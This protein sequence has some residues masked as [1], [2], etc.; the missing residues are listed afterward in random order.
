[1]QE[2]EWRHCGRPD[3]PADIGQTE[4][5]S[6]IGDGIVSVQGQMR[7]DPDLAMKAIMKRTG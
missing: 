5:E 7:I 2:N 4:G 3:S 1:M 6:V